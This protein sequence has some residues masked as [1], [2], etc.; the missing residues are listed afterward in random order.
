MHV[1]IIHNHNEYPQTYLLLVQL[2]RIVQSTR[3]VKGRCNLYRRACT[4]FI[5]FTFL[6]YRFDNR[7]AFHRKTECAVYL[8]HSFTTILTPRGWNEELV[9]STSIIYEYYLRVLSTRS[10][11]NFLHSSFW[12]AFSRAIYLTFPSASPPDSYPIFKY[13]TNFECLKKENLQSP[14]WRYG[15]LDI[16]HRWFFDNQDLCQI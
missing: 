4:R 5:G 15:E 3:Q 8:A 6:L 11:Q 16:R 1:V 2:I 9:L 14:C 12:R 10:Y 13:L 7:Q